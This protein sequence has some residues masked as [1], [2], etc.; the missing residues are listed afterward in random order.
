MTQLHS[1]RLCLLEQMISILPDG[2]GTISE[3]K[4]I[5][6]SAFIRLYC[7]LKSMAAF[8]YV[9]LLLVKKY[10][11][12]FISFHRLI[13]VPKLAVLYDNSFSFVISNRFTDEEMKILLRLITSRPPLS[14]AGAR[15][16]SL[17]LCMLI[18]CPYLLGLVVI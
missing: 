13:V 12:I 10:I 14:K 6:A 7:A 4:A 3:S 17:G 1:L 15:F 18:A 11:T 16:V 8:K 5:K 2:G 9:H